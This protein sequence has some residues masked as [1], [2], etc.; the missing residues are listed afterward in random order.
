M[1]RF[2]HKI[3]SDQNM[4]RFALI[5]T[6]LVFMLFYDRAGRYKQR[7]L[8]GDLL[9]EVEHLESGNDFI[10]SEEM[11]DRVKRKFQSEYTNVPM[12]RFSLLEMEASLKSLDFIKTADVYVDGN[13]RLNVYITQREPVFRL[14][15]P[16]G[17]SFYV[18][19]D[20]TTMP[21]SM[22][23]SPRVVV[24]FAPIS[25]LKDTLAISSPGIEQDV[26]RLAQRIAEDRILNALVEEIIVDELGEWTLIP[27]MGPSRIYLGRLERLEEKITAL[28]KVYKEILPIEG[29]DKYYSVNLKYNGQV[30]CSK[31]A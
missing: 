23:Y 13:N 29:W 25:I 16:D 1:K 26:Y 27:K 5:G 20:G 18:D 19:K 3:T 22:H 2:F 12:S 10:T 30:I 8:S 7:S 11:R 21:S 9:I 6:A 4:L 31:R 17:H 24:V 28:K 14:L 15:T